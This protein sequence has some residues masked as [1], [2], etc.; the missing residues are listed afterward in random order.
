MAAR[1]TRKDAFSSYGITLLNVNW[2]L[3]GRSEKDRKVAVSIWK[4]DLT[5][6]PGERVYDRPSWGDWYSGSG[7]R[8]FFADLAWAREHCDGIVRIV[9]S[10]RKDG[11][12][13]R[14][15]VAESHADHDLRMRVTRMD[16]ETG[17][18]RLEEVI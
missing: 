2:S 12:P 4:H 8:Y 10:I 16:P 18:F 17:A 13:E 6:P 5:G 9:L 7:R 15:R 14:V 1:R 11:E 3:S